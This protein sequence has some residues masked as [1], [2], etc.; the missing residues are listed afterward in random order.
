MKESLLEKTGMLLLKKGY[1]L[2][3]LSRTCFDLL[4]KSPENILLIKIL[5]DANAITKEYAEDMLKISSYIKASPI[6]VAEKA[7]SL[8]RENV[9]YMRFNIVTLNYQTLNSSIEHKFPFL[10]RDQTGLTAQINSKR[11]RKSREEAGMSL[12]SL[13]KKLGVSSRMIS[14]YEDGKTHITLNKA[15][16]LYDLFGHKVF[17]KVNVFSTGQ[18][19]SEPKT[20]ISHKYI[21][22]GFE[23]AD[24][25]KAPFDVIA[26]KER[27]I[28]LTEIGDKSNPQIRSLSKLIDADTLAIF[29]KKRP[30]EIPA[31]T[32]KEFM[33]FEKASELIKFLKEFE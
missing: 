25:R 3:Q 1:T 10:R 4:A 31:L 30:K 27:D 18:I 20:T 24:T 22:L 32:K 29:K 2:K 6:V 19:V 26:K 9:V 8:L 15:F 28:V 21:N 23:A 7:G 5:E 14:K 11:L 12:V 13:A 17:E 33:E 16:K